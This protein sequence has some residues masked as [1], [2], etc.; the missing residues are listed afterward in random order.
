MTDLT[1]LRNLFTLSDCGKICSFTT[2]MD[3]KTYLT[4]ADVLERLEGKWSKSDNAFMFNYDAAETVDRVFSSGEIPKRNPNQFHPTPREQVLDMLNCSAQ[5]ISNLNCGVD[6]FGSNKPV[7]MLEPSIG[8]CGIA[9]IVKELYPHVQITGIEI[10]EVNAKLA[11]EAGFNVIEGDFLSQPIPESEDEKF[12]VVIMNPPFKTRD[13][14][15]HIRHAQAMLKKGGNLVSIAPSSWMAS[16]SLPAEV[17]FMDEATR[18]NGIM[19]EVYGSRTY[20]HTNVETCIVEMLHPEDY[21]KLIEDNKGYWV[22]MATI[23]ME[24]DARFM[25]KFDAANPYEKKNILKE[26]LIR[27]RNKDKSPSAV[28][29]LEQ[30]YEAINFEEMECA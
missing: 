17:A 4:L 6:G 30:V 29:L 11:R 18:T 3:R 13:F 5:L 19:R 7:R 25:Q 21:A 15:K 8:R 9:N 1:Q 24:N 14:I 27:Q 23:E 16:A 2:Q 10:D 26:E 28:D 20:E 22:H 12:D